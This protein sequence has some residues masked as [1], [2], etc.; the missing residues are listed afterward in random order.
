M[1]NVSVKMIEAGNLDNL[2]WEVNRFLRNEYIDDD[3]L[4]NVAISS[5][6]HNDSF[7]RYDR[8]IAAITYR[9]Q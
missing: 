2:E 1:T 5:Y 9:K 3:D 8:Y 7:T 6:C 4:I